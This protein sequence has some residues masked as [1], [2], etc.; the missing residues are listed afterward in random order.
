M[1]QL[2]NLFVY[3]D[4]SQRSLFDSFTK[5]FRHNPTYFYRGFYVTGPEFLFHEE[6]ST[7]LANFLALFLRNKFPSYLLRRILSLNHHFSAPI[8]RTKLL[9]SLPRRIHQLT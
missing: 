4:S 5:N 2:E 3:S 6:I 7:R 8:L 9:F 1:V